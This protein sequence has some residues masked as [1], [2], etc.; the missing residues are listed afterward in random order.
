MIK[1]ED[2]NFWSAV[3]VMGHLQ[4]HFAEAVPAI[5]SETMFLDDQ[6]PRGFGG[7]QGC[8]GLDGL[9]AHEQET[10][11]LRGAGVRAL[12]YGPDPIGWS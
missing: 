12:E 5:A 1:P 8:E 10:E 2:Q 3:P 7:E 4:D 11:P 6:S 9:C